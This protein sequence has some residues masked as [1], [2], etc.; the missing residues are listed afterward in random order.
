MTATDIWKH[1]YIDTVVK[2][3][4]RVVTSLLI[5]DAKRRVCLAVDALYLS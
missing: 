5:T 1:R 2:L 4:R 3:W